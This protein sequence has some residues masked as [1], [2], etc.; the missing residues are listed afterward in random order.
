MEPPRPRLPDNSD[1]SSERISPNMFVV[2]MTSNFGGSNQKSDGSVD[3][4]FVGFNIG[5]IRPELANLPQEQRIGQAQHIGF[6]NR[7]T[8]RR[9]RRAISNAARATRADALAVTFRSDRAMSGSGMNSPV[10]GEHVPIGIEVLGVLAHDD[11]IH[12]LPKDRQI[13]TGKARAYIRVNLELDP[14]F[15]GRV[16]AASSRA[17]YS[18]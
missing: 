16:D 9:R 18:L 3:D 8:L 4:E 5:I 11:D 10:S 14:Q 13:R 12:R 7:R 17:G 15:A 2:T 1:A 6:M